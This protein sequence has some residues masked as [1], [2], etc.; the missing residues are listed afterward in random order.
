VQKARHPS[1]R[2]IRTFGPKLY[3]NIPRPT[4]QELGGMTVNERLVMCS[5]FEKWADAVK[6]R[7][8]VDMVAVL[9]SV[10]FTESQA[11]QT[12]DAVL[13]NSGFYGF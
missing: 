7:N 3:M 4:D 6:R 13:K 9:M 5:A 2:I 8:R 12:T 10:A 1:P 11:G